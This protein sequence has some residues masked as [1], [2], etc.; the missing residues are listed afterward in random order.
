MNNV[1]TLANT[2]PL[3][4]SQK[5]IVEHKPIPPPRK[6]KFRHLGHANSYED[7]FV[8]NNQIHLTRDGFK[9]VF[10]H[11]LGNEPIYQKID[12]NQNN[13]RTLPTKPLRAGSNLKVGNSKSDKFFGEN[14]SEALSDE[15]FKSASEDFVATIHDQDRDDL[16]NFIQ[17]NVSQLSLA[18]SPSDGLSNMHV[19]AVKKKPYFDNESNIFIPNEMQGRIKNNINHYQKSEHIYAEVKRSKRDG[20]S[21]TPAPR[22]PQRA[23]ELYLKN[24]EDES[25]LHDA[26]RPEFPSPPLRRKKSVNTEPIRCKELNQLPLSINLKESPKVLQKSASSHSFLTDN[27]M[28]SLVNRVYSIDNISIEDICQNSNQIDGS[29]AVSQNIQKLKTRKISSQRKI[30]SSSEQFTITTPESK[31]SIT[32][33]SSTLACDTEPTN[34]KEPFND[35]SKENKV[36]SSPELLQPPANDVKV[37]VQNTIQNIEKPVEQVNLE[38]IVIDQ[39]KIAPLMSSSDIVRELHQNQE[40]VIF[41]FQTFL[42][43]ELNKSNPSFRPKYLSDVALEE[44]VRQAIE[45]TEKDD[46]SQSDDLEDWQT[47]NDKLLITCS[48]SGALTIPLETNEIL[49]SKVDEPINKNLLKVSRLHLRRESIEDVD[50]W[51]TKH[52]D[53]HSDYP[54]QDIAN[55]TTEK[56]NF[57]S[58]SYDH[59][60]LFPFGDIRTRHDSMNDEFFDAKPNS[61]RISKNNSISED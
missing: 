15:P 30:S 53:I 11:K 28:R 54:I 48:E 5:I 34:K 26:Q 24:Q 7:V 16:D 51:F 35:N 50:N 46:S 43:D 10:G 37:E 38:N 23:L 44:G 4:L 47:K 21:Q 2:Q 29:M 40:E 20:F 42:E 17:D 49:D 32:N 3:T 56:T 33:Q 22:K 41:A 1:T 25:I 13:N 9:E 18:T 45:R 60:K 55:E 59:N 61:P 8:N 14:L 39:L 6:K 52:V 36:F 57:Q 58:T 12:E 31:I 27:L 19:E